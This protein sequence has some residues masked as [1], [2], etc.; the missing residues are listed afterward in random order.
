MEKNALRHFKICLP[1]LGLFCLVALTAP[2]SA[3]TVKPNTAAGL[4]NLQV[5]YTDRP[6]GID[7][8]LPRFGWQ[9]KA[10]AGARG[11][12][13]LAYQIA[14]TDGEGKSV[15]NT[16]KINS[17]IS[18]GIEYAGKKLKAATRYT[19]KLTVWDQTGKALTNTSWFETG[20]MDTGLSAWD[21][22]NWIGGG[23]N[24]LVLNAHYLPIFNLSYKLAIAPGSTR[25]AVILSANDARL[26]NSNLNIFQVANKKDESYFKVELDITAVNSAGTGTA[27]INVYRSG[28]TDNDT[29]GRAIKT[30]EVK[31]GIINDGN[32][33]N[34]K[35]LSMTSLVPSRSRLMTTTLFLLITI[36]AQPRY[37]AHSRHA[38]RNARLS[39]LIR[40]AKG[41]M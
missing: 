15:W 34:I 8:T 22:S 25:A 26:M 11:Y 18:S 3:Q 21:G 28:Y 7:V 37:R 5:E 14:V 2:A 17:S 38:G 16:G 12:N 40:L 39:P 27:K 9:M 4:D 23:D 36:K 20:L 6:L 33:R 31:P 13:Q 35:F 29:A 19:W 1:A 30:F 24:D 41:M 32:T 10:P